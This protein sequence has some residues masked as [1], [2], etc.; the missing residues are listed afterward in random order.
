MAP[1]WEHHRSG[2]ARGGAIFSI[3]TVEVVVLAAL[4]LILFGPQRMPELLR[5]LGKAAAELRRAMASVTHELEEAARLEEPPDR[6]PD[7]KR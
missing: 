1:A 5:T 4:V 6:T 3:G 2:S 7:R